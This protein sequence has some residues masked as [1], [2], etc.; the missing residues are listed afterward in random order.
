MNR[1]TS[2]LV[3][4]IASLDLGHDDSLNVVIETP[5]GSRNKFKFDQTAGMFKLS[6]VL[7]EGM[8]FPYDFGFIPSTQAEDGDPLDVLVLM[9]EPTFPGCLLQCRLV[10]VI[11]ALQEEKG[12]EHRNDRLIAVASQSIRYS[13]VHDLDDLNNAVLKQV[14]EFFINYQR[15]RGVKFKILAREGRRKA[16]RMLEERSAAK[17][18]HVTKA[19]PA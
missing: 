10:G 9:D 14:E 4:P 5:K 13:D 16:A 15:V 7:P 6:K 18:S 17:S 19:R 1:K 3:T 12:E 2:A 11:E 8:M